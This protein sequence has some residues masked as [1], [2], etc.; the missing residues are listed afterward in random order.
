LLFVNFDE[1]PPD[2]GSLE[3]AMAPGLRPYG[4]ATAKVAHRQ[5]YPIASNWKLAIENYCECYHC[6][7][8]HPEYSS[9]TGALCRTRSATPSSP[10]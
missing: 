5:N 7:P 8:A 6:Q 2:F 9:D 1:H 10:R 3:R 4:L